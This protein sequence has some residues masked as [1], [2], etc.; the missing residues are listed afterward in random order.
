MTNG[1]EKLDELIY[2]SDSDNE[3]KEA[4]VWVDKQALQKGISMIQMMEI[5]LERRMNRISAKEW[6]QN[7][8]N[9]FD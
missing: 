6:V 7:L 1:Q 4:L 8:Q 9:K 3:L 5:I 2:L